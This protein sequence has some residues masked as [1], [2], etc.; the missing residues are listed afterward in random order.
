MLVV[1]VVR[2]ALRVERNQV[3]EEM[4]SPKRNGQQQQ[5]QQQWGPNCRPWPGP[6]KR[7]EGDIHFFWTFIL[8][9]GLDAAFTHTYRRR[10]ASLG[11]EARF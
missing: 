4:G 2:M 10:S 7:A 11:F 1:A 9:A 5:Q 8:F 3:L 6:A